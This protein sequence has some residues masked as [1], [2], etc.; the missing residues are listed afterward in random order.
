MES[1]IV[2][3]KRSNEHPRDQ[4]TFRAATIES[5][6]VLLEAIG[7][8][9]SWPPPAGSDARTLFALLAFRHTQATRAE[10]GRLLGVTG[11]GALYL[12]RQGEERMNEDPLFAALVLEGESRLR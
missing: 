4:R 2:E 11:H 5:V 9:S 1:R 8:V 6:R 10:I 12:I 3:Q 7:Q